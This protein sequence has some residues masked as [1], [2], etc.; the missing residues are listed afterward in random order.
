MFD[1]WKVLYQMRMSLPLLVFLLRIPI[2]NGFQWF[3]VD[4]KCPMVQ[5]PNLQDIPRG[6]RKRPKVKKKEQ[7]MSSQLSAPPGQTFSHKPGFVELVEGDPGG[8]ISCTTYP[9]KAQDLS[10]PTS[11][12]G[13]YL[14]IIWFPNQKQNRN[15]ALPSRIQHTRL[16]A[17]VWI[18]KPSPTATKLWGLKLHLVRNITKA[19][20][21]GDDQRLM[22][23]P[24]SQEGGLEETIR[25]SLASIKGKPPWG[26]YQRLLDSPRSLQ[27]AATTK[28]KAQV[29]RDQ[30]TD[31]P[32]YTPM[33]RFGFAIRIVYDPG[34]VSACSSYKGLA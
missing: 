28:E 31:P 24:A 2:W 9:W 19:L 13:A 21:L 30:A 16:L 22:L 25:D 15:C 27:S 1:K 34:G 33:S 6:P 23:E 18:T 11:P 29:L 8:I 32:G 5:H 7:N 10:F 26:P 14:E 20:K 4:G 17:S 12:S 3:L